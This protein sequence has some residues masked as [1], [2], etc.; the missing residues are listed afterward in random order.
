MLSFRVTVLTAVL[1]LG[2]TAAQ[3]DSVFP[4]KPKDPTTPSGQRLS[5]Y[6]QDDVVVAWATYEPL[7]KVCVS[8]GLNEHSLN[9]TV[10]GGESHTIPDTRQYQHHVHLKGLTPDRNYFYK[11]Q[12]T[13]S[14]TLPFKAAKAVGAEG[15][16]SFGLVTDLGLYGKEGF[17]TPLTPLVTL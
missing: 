4:P 2:A 6:A 3:A 10:C 5:L 7:D 1:L 16:F 12:S 8:Y 13:N 14:T 11:I 17:G 15:E 9:N